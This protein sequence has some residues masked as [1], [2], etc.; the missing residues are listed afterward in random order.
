MGLW[1]PLNTCFCKDS[2]CGLFDNIYFDSF[3]NSLIT[4]RLHS[5]LAVN[6]LPA[7]WLSM[8]WQRWWHTG[9]GLWLASAFL[10]IDRYAL[11]TSKR[12]SQN[13]WPARSSQNNVEK[14]QFCSLTKLPLIY[15]WKFR[16]SFSCKN[17][18]LFVR[19]GLF[20][21]LF[22]NLWSDFSYR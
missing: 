12:N 15:W 21:F 11:L 13:L 8:P 17:F 22:Q 6:C 5:D 20:T 7:D 18:F 4:N 16:Y 1:L 19:V 2:I 14:Q 9:P 10:K 3:P